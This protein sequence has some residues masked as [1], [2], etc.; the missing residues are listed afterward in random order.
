[1]C[2]KCLEAAQEIYPELTEQDRV[3]LLWE[4]TAFPFAQPEHIRKQLMDHKANTDGSVQA[5]INRAA[6]NMDAAMAKIHKDQE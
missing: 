2:I 3:R 4:A 5:A 1:M 6:E